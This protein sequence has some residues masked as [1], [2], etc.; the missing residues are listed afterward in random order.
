MY[1]KRPPNGLFPIKVNTRDGT[2]AD[3]HITFGALG[4]SFYEYLLKVWIQGGKKEDWLREMYDSA[5]E[6]MI[7]K[8]LMVSTPSGL[9]Y[10]SDWN[11]H[12]NEHKMGNLTHIRHN[13]TRTHHNL[14][15][16]LDH[17]VCF[18]PGTM[19]LGAYTD[20][21]GLQSHRAQRDLAVAKA[22]M[23]TCYRMYHDMKSGISAEFVEFK[24]G[25]NFT[26]FIPR[27]CQNFN[28]NST[29]E[30]CHNF[31][32]I[33]SPTG[34]DFV[35]G[36]NVA[37]YILRPETAESLFVLNQLTGDPIY[38]EWAWEIWESIER[39]CKTAIAFGSLSNVRET[40]STVDDRMES[41]FL[42]ETVKYLYLAQV[43]VQPSLTILT[44][45]C[46]FHFELDHFELGPGQAR[47]PDQGSF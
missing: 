27:T 11:G 25:H 3:N 22:L 29:P 36:P 19:A 33:S 16:T 39:E 9:A 23:Y 47:G 26:R 8:L 4:D 7:D 34:R 42:A 17:L 35:P 31:N 45:G 24:K 43:C 20:P 12:S 38:R 37:F 5:I 28:A 15:Q 18:M 40:H 46:N 2:F 6:G 1:E 13:L 30:N 44:S 41:F 10:I 32:A 14:T 21:L